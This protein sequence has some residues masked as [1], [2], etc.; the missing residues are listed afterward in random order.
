MPQSRSSFSAE[1]PAEKIDRAFQ[2]K[3][4]IIDRI[5]EYQGDNHFEV[6]H[7]SADAREARLPAVA[8]FDLTE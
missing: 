4:P 2:N 1:Y 7:V 8:A 5:I 6:P 3:A